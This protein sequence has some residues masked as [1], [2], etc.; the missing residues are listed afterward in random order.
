MEEKRKAFIL[1]GDT[2]SGL[3]ISRSLGQRDIPI[4]TFTFPGEKFGPSK[5]ITK[6][7]DYKEKDSLLATLQKYGQREKKKPVLF[8]T[9]ESHIPFLLEHE[10]ELKYYY[11]FPGEKMGNWKA[12]INYEKAKGFARSFGIPT[13]EEISVKDENLPGFISSFSYPYLGIDENRQEKFKIHNKK[14]LAQYLE[15]A[16]K[17]KKDYKILRRIPGATNGIYTFH[18][19][20]GEHSELMAY[21]IYRQMKRNNPYFGEPIM[22]QQCWNPK[23]YEFSKSIVQEGHYRGYVECTFK[24]DPTTQN[25]YLL[26]I[27]LSFGPYLK[28]FK[29]LDVDFP[30]LYYL[31]AQGLTLDHEKK[32]LNYQKG[33]YGKVWKFDE[34]DSTE[35]SKFLKPIFPRKIG[36]LW[37]PKDPGPAL[38]FISNKIQKKLTNILTTLLNLWKKYRPKKKRAPIE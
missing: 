10:K 24:E 7:I 16:S 17:D 30:Y 38:T 12:F 1:N 8:P 2:Y 3:Q 22:V 26:S 25:T 28:F 11:I 31:D 15:M 29:A 23:I 34:E 21:G 35:S 20:F 33:I 13:P 27:Q 36:G 32:F 14:D 19:Y 9:E 37:D 5:Y 6:T 18:G 4:V